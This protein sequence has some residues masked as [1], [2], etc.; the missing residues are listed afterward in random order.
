M[1]IKQL[2]LLSSLSLSAVIGLGV[3]QSVEAKH[4]RHY[5]R[6][7][8]HERHG[9][10]GRVYI[11]ARDI[12]YIRGMPYHRYHRTPVYIVR[13]RY[14]YPV[15]YYVFDQYSDYDDD[16]YRDGRY[17]YHDYG[18]YIDRDGITI[19]YRNR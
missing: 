4:G 7:D 10:H 5:D 6:H 17:R 1:N 18:R 9:N 15:S 19:I 11:S 12:I 2:I 3:S 14:G 13:D 16:Y 8:W